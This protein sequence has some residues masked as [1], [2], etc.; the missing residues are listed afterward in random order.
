VDERWVCE[1]RAE[2]DWL[3]DGLGAVRDA[4]VLLDRFTNDIVSLGDSDQPA[5]QRLLDTLRARR[6]HDRELLLTAMRSSRYGALLDALVAAARRPRLLLRIDDTDD[7]EMLLSL[8]R[9]PLRRLRR[10]VS[11]EPR[12]TTDEHLHRLRILTKRA[13]Y[14]IEALGV[15]FGRPARKHARAL[16]Q[17]QDVLGAHH[18]AVV[19][20]DWLRE[21]TSLDPSLGLVAGQLVELERRRADAA[22][23]SWRKQWHAT[24]R[25]QLHS[26]L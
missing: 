18:D 13:R 3:A 16:A 5:G 22:A 25:K 2:L 4:D 23:G 19:A 14:A 17:L 26:W 6:T 24:S 10:A 8:V 9:V 21:R 11:A 7:E 1:L 20:A 15:A 12:D